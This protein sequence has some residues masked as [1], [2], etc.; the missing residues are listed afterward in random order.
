MSALEAANN[1]EATDPVI[2]VLTETDVAIDDLKR[3]HFFTAIFYGLPL[4]AALMGNFSALSWQLDYLH[5]YQLQF[6][7]A[8]CALGVLAILMRNRV[9]MRMAGLTIAIAI[10][11]MTPAIGG[12]IN[13][14][15]AIPSDPIKVISFNVLS[16]NDDQP[17]IEAWLRAQNAPIVALIEANYRWADTAKR[18]LDIYPHQHMLDD[19]GNYGI[20]LLSQY[21]LSNIEQLKARQHTFSSIS[22]DVE[23]PGKGSLRILA[24]H[25][26][27]PL[28]ENYMAVRDYEI[29]NLITPINQAGKPVL[30]MGD[31][32]AVPWTRS[33]QV[34]A[35][36]TRLNGMEIHPSWPA[37]AN[38]LG[39]PIDYILGANGALITNHQSG[40]RLSSDHLPKIAE[41]SVR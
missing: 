3:R 37:S 17:M 36:A 12:A 7:Y 18:L 30:L 10:M 6:M 9:G 34:L 24:V 2:A 20:I 15:K 1:N 4:L 39:L 26:P 8:G 27:P 22:A 14:A 5:Q 13:T 40:P 32:N 38:L 28:N 16:T 31:L 19:L 21:P 29:A 41:L 35:D 11:G 33:V 23:V 25:V